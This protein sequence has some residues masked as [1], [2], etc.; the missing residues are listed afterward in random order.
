[1]MS[2]LKRRSVLVGLGFVMLA[3]FLWFAG[4]F[5]AFADWRPLET[6]LARAVL[7]SALVACWVGVELGKRWK[8]RQASSRLADAMAQ[9]GAPSAS[10][11]E[12]QQ[13]RERFEDALARLKHKQR[14]GHTLYELP[15]Y[16][17]I[18]A[19]GSG[20]TTALVNSGLRFSLEQ[21]SGR[22]ALKG[23]GGTRN[24]DWWFTDEAVFLDTAGRYTTQDSDASA[25]SAGW[26]EFLSL[27]RKHRKRRPLNGIILTI[28]AQDLM[29]SGVRE[30]DSHIAAVRR[31]LDEL[32][33]ELRIQLP[34]YLLVTKCDLVAGFTEYFDDLGADGRAQVW[35]ATFPYDK[36]LS[37]TAAG[38]YPG[39]FDA[40]IE[41]LNARLYPRVEEDHDVRRRARIFGFAQ[42]MAVLRDALLDFV[43]EVFESTR[44]DRQ[45]LLRGVY[46]TS[47]TQE[48]TPID[49]LLGA[50]GQQY[51]MSP[52]MVAPASRGKAYFIERLLKQVIL[53][54]SGLAGV[55]RRMEV[56]KAAAQLVAYVSMALIAGAGLV[57]LTVSYRAN[58]T[59]VDRVAASVEAL[60]NIPATPSGSPLELVLPRL[61]AMSTVSSVANEFRDDVPVSMRW[62]LFQGG[63]LGNAALDAYGRE[64][65][66]ALLPAVASR[67]RDRLIDYAAQPDRLFEYLKAYLMLGEPE[68]LN[69]THLSVL[70]DLEWRVAYAGTPEVG[71]SL[72]RHF[73]T[74]LDIKDPLPP[75]GLDDVVVAQ[76]RSTIGQASIPG[77]MYSQLRLDH[78]DEP[79]RALR[80]DVTMGL[81]AEQVFARRSGIGLS[82]PFPALYTE[83]VFKEITGRG[84]ELL[85]ARFALD[86][87]V[88]GEGAL[89][90]AGVARFGNE[91][92]GLYE[93][94]YIAAW[95]SLIQD[96]TL[97]PIRNVSQLS[98]VLG[99]LGGSTS[100]LRGFLQMTRDHTLLVE[101]ESGA[102]QG[103]LA[104]AE[105]RLGRLLGGARQAVGVPAVTPGKQV[106]DHFAPLHR[107][108]DGSG[109]GLEPI[110]Q[111]IAR[112][113]QELQSVGGG[114]GERPVIDV[115]T[116]PGPRA[117][118]EALRQSASTLP[119][120]VGG[121]VAE[122]GRLAG[123][124]VTSAGGG[125]IANRYRQEVVAECRAIAG[126]YPF[127]PTSAQDVPLADFGRVFGYGGVFD[128]F[129]DEQLSRL[130]DTQRSPWQWRQ[131]EA[132][133]SLNAP[134]AILRQVE[135][136][137]RIRDMFFQPGSRTPEVQFTL[138][139]AELDAEALRFRLE[140]DGQ[141]IEDRHAPPRGVRGRW[142]GPERGMVVATFEDRSETVTAMAFEGDWALFRMLQAARPQADSAERFLLT[143][144]GGSH[145]ARVTLEAGSLRNPFASPELAQFRCE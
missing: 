106:T 114:L 132:G 70:A 73:R 94:D 98:Q 99:I 89:S 26:T 61:D 143:F 69:K 50:L 15:W 1:M 110:V 92:L 85:A 16:V 78:L 38:T 95:D 56:Q 140:V 67:F 118:I 17:F 109:G 66:G 117:A 39:E 6:V 104:E 42:Q 125:E 45:V 84:T 23:V 12:A 120:A 72:S 62:G 116:Q 9:Q 36:T 31:R 128:R 43:S 145:R 46:F 121:V 87:W 24:C 11:A 68:H 10:S 126:R 91:V 113:Q 7:F 129:F 138:T 124:T 76:A 81:G 21:R 133:A 101:P 54:E 135:A 55:N 103:A 18:G 108:V 59:Y 97:V 119:P 14:S 53:P 130:V 4:P 5:F 20:K 48:G 25:D 34:V 82:E 57:A 144:E 123:A 86:S 2:F 29:V 77:I 136:A 102:S 74:L 13:I 52:D 75:V 122:L 60:Q 115:L 112:V 40:L 142:P 79:E 134:V 51:D 71:T 105:R 28:S 33:R 83:P 111:Q 22:G 32:N 3:L 47:G 131:G 139:P 107:L 96:L 64:L 88:W 41:R 49:R 35:G 37:G 8:A 100:P 93:R 58:R 65:D 30:R 141:V 19:P 137:R 27:L 63:S 127:Q 44:F 90:V 80:L